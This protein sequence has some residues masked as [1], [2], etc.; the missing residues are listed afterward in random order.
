MPVRG[1]ASK[2]QRP[3]IDPDQNPFVSASQDR[4][5]SLSKAGILLRPEK[6]FLGRLLQFRGRK[7]PPEILTVLKPRLISVLQQTAVQPKH[8]G[9]MIEAAALQ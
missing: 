7:K 5:A 4:T 6:R 1:D 8:I 3:M 9:I 2:S